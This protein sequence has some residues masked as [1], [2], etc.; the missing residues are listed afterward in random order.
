LKRKKKKVEDCES[1]FARK[2]E[3]ESWEG[4]SRELKTEL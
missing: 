3:I 4:N 2:L 1:R